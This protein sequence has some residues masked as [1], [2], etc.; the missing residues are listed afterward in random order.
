ML[1]GRFKVTIY[2]LLR[3]LLKAAS[4]NSPLVTKELAAD[5]ATLINHLEASGALGTM[6]S[7][8]Q[9]THEF[10]PSEL[11]LS[12]SYGKYKCKICGKDRDS[13]E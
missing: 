10:M 2:D 13:H 3:L 8:I 9:E 11:E 5:G 6:S 4:R 1:S 7:M 12:R